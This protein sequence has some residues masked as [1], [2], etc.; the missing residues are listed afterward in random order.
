LDQGLIDTYQAPPTLLPDKRGFQWEPLPSDKLSV[1][2]EPGLAST[3]F[4]K[5]QK[6]VIRLYLVGEDVTP[7][8]WSVAMKVRLPRGGVVLPSVDER[9]GID[10][11]HDWYPQTLVWD[12]WPI[13]LGFLNAAHRPAGKHGHVKA[14]GD[15][16]VFEDGTPARFWGTNLEAYALFNGSK[17]DIANQAKRIAALGYNLVRLHH[18]DSPWVK[19]NA[20]A[21]GANTQA[22]NE[23]AFDTFDWWV[24]CLEDEGIYVWMDLNVERNFLPGDN[25]DGYAE[26][27]KQKGMGKGFNYV[28][29]RIEKLMQD[30]A[31]HYLGRVNRYTNRPYAQ[32]PGVMGI[33][34]TNENDI[35]QHFGNL[36]LPDKGNPVHEKMLERTWRGTGQRIGTPFV[37]SAKAYDLGP[38][39][40]VLSELERAFF[41][42]S[43]DHLRGLGV[44]AL[45]AGTNFWGEEGAYSL[46]SL[47][48][49]DV[50]D[51]HSYGKAE[52]LGANP[53]SDANFISWI[54]VAQ[55]AGKPMTITEWNV[56][57]PNR[58]RFVAPLYLAAIASLQGWDAPML[59]GY[60]QTPVQE[61]DKPDPWSTWNDPG[62]TAVMPAAAIMF[63]QGHVRE[64]KKTYRLDLSRDA[65]YYQNTNPQTSRAIRTLV[66]QSKLTIGLPDASPKGGDAIVFNDTGRDFLPMGQEFVQSDTEEIKRD[67][68]QGVETIDTPKSQGAMGWIG[69]RRIH[70]SDVDFDLRTRKASI[71][72]TSL[73]NKPIASSERLLV[74]AVAQVASSPDNKLPYLAEPIEGTILLRTTRHLRLVPLSP[75]GEQAKPA[76]SD[77]RAPAVPASAAG[78]LTFKLTRGVPTHWFLLV[79]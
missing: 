18:H 53:R 21:E 78:Q 13:D 38:A 1:T 24:K 56:E 62:V 44:N 65:L 79:P 57:Y 45:V 36:M 43:I 69:G 72:V 19:P 26:L 64:A 58:D 6:N 46:P 5:G 30:F 4:E 55:V 54:G 10:D 63:R 42:R 77:K 9:Y 27:A 35:T 59:Y 66:E 51:V 75:S 50:I 16:L 31:A 15:K 60:L 34:V 61:P 17:P 70:L 52:S 12:K 32:D 49:G 40:M 76:S 25:I 37:S 67:W 48:A 11:R 23:E 33:L 14:Q 2:F 74:T 7:S 71:V 41:R 22:L 39:K 29:S 47:A 68:S 8:S 3:F 20:I 73:D 28:D